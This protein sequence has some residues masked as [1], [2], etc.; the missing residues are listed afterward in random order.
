[1][2][3]NGKTGLPL[4]LMILVALLAGCND[5]GKDSEEGQFI[6]SHGAIIR[7]NP[8]QREVA[9]VVTGGDYSDGGQHIKTVL[10]QKGVKASFFFTGDF[11]RDSSNRKLVSQLIA[12][13]HYIGPH[14]NRHPLY[15]SWEKRDSLLISESAFR[16]DLEANYDLLHVFGI[17]KSRARYFIPP[18][19]WYND[20][21]AAW[22]RQMD[23]ILI[24]YTPGT[25]SPA[26]YTIPAMDNYRSAA[27]ILTSI[28]NYERRDPRGLNG[29]LLLI[30]IET[31]PER[32]DKFYWRLSELID[33]L[34]SSGYRLMRVDELLD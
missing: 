33:Y 5:A 11:L 27:E 19:E 23:V 24:N 30:H 7:G 3:T 2:I 10:H 6:L 9:L 17:P 12:D 28:E 21:I 4:V 22:T 34:F 18:Y 32:I 13:G 26:D 15:C 25:L 20:S 14:S 8:Q 31:H 1:M 16:A 29:F